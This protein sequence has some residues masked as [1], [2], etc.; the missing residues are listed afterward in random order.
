MTGAR[1]LSKLLLDKMGSYELFA[2]ADF[3][4]QVARVTDV[5]HHD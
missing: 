4:L 3:K 1:Q 2:R 5:I